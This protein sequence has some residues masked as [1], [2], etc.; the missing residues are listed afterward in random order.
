MTTLDLK[1]QIE[2]SIMAFSQGNFRE[3]GIRL[4]KSLGYASNRQVTIEPNTFA[5]FV[6][7][8]P[9]L[10]KM[11]KQKA[12]V[13]DWLSVDILFQLTGD[14]LKQ[15]TQGHLIFDKSRIDNQI[16]ESY[17]FLAIELKPEDYSRTK[18]ADVTREVNKFFA[19]PVMILF[20]HGDLLTLSII[21]RR[22]HKKDES[23]D[24]LEKVTLIKGIN[25]KDPIRAHV[26]ILFD[27][28]L[29]ELEKAG[30]MH[31]FVEL[32]KAWQK[33]LDTSTLNKKFYREIADWY[34][35][36]VENVEFPAGTIP[37]RQ[38]RNA[39]NTIRLIT[40][41]IFV[42]F[43]KEKGLVPDTLFD[44]NQLKEI[45]YFNDPQNS[46]YYKAI[47]QNL[48]FATL[49]TEMGSERR[50]RGKNKNPNGLDAHFGIST[51][52]RYED[53]F[54]DPKKGLDLFTGIP[55]LNGG[56]FECLDKRDDKI[57]VDGFSDDPRNQPIVPDSLF[58]GDDLTVD[59]SEVYGDKHHDKEKV[60]GLIRIFNSYKFTIEENTP[61]DEEIAL[62][63]ELLGKVFENLLAAY[64]PETGTTARKQTGSFYTPREIVNYMVD[65]SLIAY[66]ENSLQTEELAAGDKS[67]LESK[68]RHLL[69]YNNEPHQF[70][71]SE[72]DQI[73]SAI[74]KVKVLDPACGSGAFPMG[75]LHKLVFILNKLDPGNVKWKERQIEKAS[76]IPD[77]TVRDQV[78]E[79]IEK[80]FSDNELDYGRK[81]YL[82]ENC[83]YGVD[84]QPIAVQIAKLRFFI[85]LVVD[86]ITNRS[87][88]N[89]G[90]R[91]LPNL[92]SKF[93]AANTL[94]GI[95]KPQQLLLHNP[96]IDE[97][98]KQLAE[99]RDS[100]FTA[101]T[102]ATK[103]KYR[104]LD[105]KLRVE[106]AAL[107]KNDG[108]SNATA[109][110]IANWDPYDQNVSADFFDIE[111]M[112]GLIDG[113]HIVIGNPPYIRANNMKISL[114]DYFQNSGHYE[115]VTGKFDI[116]VLFI[117]KA[118]KLLK[119]HGVVSFII[120]YPF[121]SQNYAMLL[122]NF[123]LRRCSIDSIYDLSELKVFDAAVAPCIVIFREEAN[124]KN[125]INNFINIRKSNSDFLTPLTWDIPQKVF[126]ATFQN[127][128]RINAVAG[129]EK[130]YELMWHKS[131]PFSDYCYIGIGID[132]HDSKTG[133]NKSARIF[134]AP[135]GNNFKPYVEGKN[136]KKYS[137]PEWNRFLEYIPEKMHRPKYPEMFETE[138][139]LVQVVVGREGIVAT[140]DRDNLFAEQ[141]L[142]VCVPKH[143][144]AHTGK[145][146]TEASVDQIELSINHGLPY[147]LGL[148]GSNLLNWYFRT[149]L[150]DELHV[151]P[152]NLRQ[153][154]IRSIN[155]SVDREKEIYNSIAD[156]VLQILTKKRK[157]P[158]SNTIDLEV[159]VDDLVYMLYGLGKEEI[160]IVEGK[161]SVSNRTISFPEETTDE[162]IG[163]ISKS[164][165][166]D[167]PL[168]SD[169]DLYKCNQCGKL[170]I[171]Y[172]REN[173]SKEN[174]HGQ[175]DWT[176]LKK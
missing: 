174:H 13:D 119:K 160:E 125:R 146:D 25:I 12:L 17:L 127:M 155:F 70:S 169:Y 41:L 77:T 168:Q 161:P 167:P 95:E 131:N 63:P 46:T 49:N 68:L 140:L 84:I 32:H 130:I 170:V 52:Y 48:F 34:F 98:E 69:A 36:A 90:I 53:Y 14:D 45:L 64:N 150:S 3:N 106:I 40:R 120:P 123:V 175:A 79:D 102:P 30:E 114:R 151:V 144:L 96:E 92:E 176:K 112:F 6:D 20:K 71:K 111:W 80:S 107:L 166:I 113:F 1:T 58:F 15:M 97:K 88:P 5:G 51:V 158:K 91:P 62:D 83:I 149:W 135:K 104:E 54:I 163:G 82:I 78:I 138:K 47:L 157:D 110:Q 39:T 172:D 44:P 101:R 75:V 122:R 129:T 164:E 72:T 8:H 23:R 22:L 11:N 55:F 31:S 143:I 93:V 42:W 10:A 9:P 118:I 159:K 57:L 87:K 141:T 86:Q 16:I 59:M 121:L 7:I 43:I 116:Y 65:E 94:I 66:L 81:L 38:T 128:Y 147:L 153:L 99:V 171:G 154:P 4:L 67:V 89:L 2:R 60:R 56:L 134:D 18:L 173:H 37:D 148:L 136:I 28:S 115:T 61:L 137:V 100:L 74:D 142:N 105:K 162:I 126:S 139:L 21:N 85:S 29:S 124:Y 165:V 152:E 108:W 73:I 50:F 109:S 145:K 76:E 103:R 117:E 26:E 27:L 132:V 24:V 133:L 35:Y 156:L 19:M 33:A